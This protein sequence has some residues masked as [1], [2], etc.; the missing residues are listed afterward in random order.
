M[1]ASDKIEA[2]MD[3]VK[4][5]VKEAA[6]KLTDNERLEAEGKLDQAKGQAKDAAEQA[7]GA[8]KDFLGE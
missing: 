1:S 2:G 7:K 5:H 4:G 6:G 3:K 8:V